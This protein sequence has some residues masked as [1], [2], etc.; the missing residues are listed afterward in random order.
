[1][2]SRKPMTKSTEK[3]KCNHTLVTILATIAIGSVIAFAFYVVERA[4]GYSFLAEYDETGMVIGGC[5]LDFVAISFSV[6]F[7]TTSLLG[8]LADKTEKIYWITY[9][10]EYLIQSVLNFFNL[11]LIS[12]LAIGVQVV[13]AL[14]KCNAFFKDSIFMSA[15]IIGTGTIII[16]SYKFTS[17]YFNREKIRLKAEKRFAAWIDAA[18]NGEKADE[19]E[20]YSAIMKMYNYTI[21]AAEDVKMTTV[22]ENILLLYAYAEKNKDCRNWIER[23]IKKLASENPDLFC[24]VLFYIDGEMNE[25]SEKNKFYQTVITN[26]DL[27]A[28]DIN[29]MEVLARFIEDIINEYAEEY[30]KTADWVGGLSP[31]E[32]E[33]LKN[34]A[35]NI[36]VL[37]EGVFVGACNNSE[38][39]VNET[40]KKLLLNILA[41]SPGLLDEETVKTVTLN[42]WDNM[43]AYYFENIRMGK[44]KTI[45]KVGELI[46]QIVTENESTYPSEYDPEMHIICRLIT[47]MKAHLNEK[48]AEIFDHNEELLG[49]VIG[50]ISDPKQQYQFCEYVGE[51]MA[52]GLMTNMIDAK[53]VGIGGTPIFYALTR[54]LEELEGTSRNSFIA[55]NVKLLKSMLQDNPNDNHLRRFIEEIL[56]MQNKDDTNWYLKLFELLKDDACALCWYTKALVFQEKYIPFFEDADAH[57]RFLEDTKELLDSLFCHINTEDTQSDTQVAIAS[58][59]T[60]I[61]IDPRGV[62]LEEYNNKCVARFTNCVKMNGDALVAI[63]ECLSDAKYELQD[64]ETNIYNYESYGELEYS[65]R[66][67]KVTKMY[68]ICIERVEELI[69]KLREKLI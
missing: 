38:L 12:Y 44:V 41:W 64:M 14:I 30:E 36:A 34:I 65:R 27:E 50:I 26:V 61:L 16:L 67:D 10:D 46:F 48:L 63:E 33:K 58:I 57:E 23:L 59:I 29:V 5:Y 17:I 24:Q 32:Y 8:G 51:V 43:L 2:N 39:Y 6:T 25:R 15:F 3:S 40:Y 52:D 9:P 68:V 21:Q 56:V 55:K 69:N 47:D 66:L 11:S 19:K 35:E 53:P 45:V 31:E 28:A 62:K 54:R 37:L 42:Y 4:L 1:M 22:C 18:N 20:V 7:L 13:F 60:S 49:K